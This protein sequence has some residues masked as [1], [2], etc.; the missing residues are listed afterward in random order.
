MEVALPPSA[1]GITA[2]PAYKKHSSSAV[3]PDDAITL[4]ARIIKF[5]HLSADDAGESDD[6]SASLRRLVS[7]ISNPETQE[8]D[9]VP[10][11]VELASLFASP[12][13]SVSS[14]ELLQS[15]VVDGLLHLIT[16][17]DRAGEFLCFLLISSTYSFPY[18]DFDTASRLILR[19]IHFTQG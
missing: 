18:S 16:E 5:K 14:F 3:D 10:A 2:I 6:L 1:S 7:C 8:K 4:R 13:T 15:G 17:S 12:H 11:L 19:R 9:L